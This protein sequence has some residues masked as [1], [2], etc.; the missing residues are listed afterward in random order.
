MLR[1]RTAKIFLILVLA[2]SQPAG[3]TS[4]RIISTT[5]AIFSLSNNKFIKQ[6]L[7]ENLF[8]FALFSRIR[9][10]LYRNGR[11][12]NQGVLEVSIFTI[13]VAKAVR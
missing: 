7:W 8:G 2:C 13:L 3:F 4:Q 10:D 9:R 12:L 5:I 11:V 6:T 1:S